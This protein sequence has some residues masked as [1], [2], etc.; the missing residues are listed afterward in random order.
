MVFGETIEILALNQEEV[1]G[2]IHKLCDAVANR[3]E[4]VYEDGDVVN[5][6]CHKFGGTFENFAILLKSKLFG[7]LGLQ[8]EGLSETLSAL[9]KEEFNKIIFSEELY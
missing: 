4:L 3:L 5:R 9:S 7:K 2:T 6:P 8:E 1:A